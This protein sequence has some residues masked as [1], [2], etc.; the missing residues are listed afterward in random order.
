MIDSRLNQVMSQLREGIRIPVIVELGTAP[1]PA[2]LQELRGAGLSVTTT[3]QISP[4]VYGTATS[5]IIGTIAANPIVVKVFYDEPLYP[6]LALPFGLEVERQEVVPLGES[7]AATGA[8]AL[9]EQGITG[10]GVKIGVV[11]TG[12]SQSHE[13]ISP[14]LKGTFSAVPGESVEDENHHGSW[15]CSAA[16]GRPVATE[17]GELVGAAPEA[18]LYALKA[19]SDKGTG[20][21]SWVMQCIEKAAVDFKCDVISMSLGSLFDNG[22]LDPVSKLVNDV[23]QKY[24]VLCAVAA[25]NSFIPLSIG[26]PGGAISA[27]TVGSYALRLPL[28]GTPSS[29]ESKGP[30]TSLVIKPDTSAPG[31]NIMAPGIAEMILAAGAHGSYQS[32]AGTSMATPQAAGALAL[33]RQAKPDL[34]RI[35]VEQ[36]LAISSFPAPKDTL[37]G[38]GPI[39]ADTMYGNMGRALPPITQFQAPLNALQSMFYAPLTLIPRPENER[40]RVVR[41]P[42]IMGG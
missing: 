11:D 22:G 16:A 14:G 27:V 30:T 1:T 23:V 24:N 25:G 26:S 40:L 34:S 9:W 17:Q 13:M 3:S 7:V 38:Y 37:R 15:C 2:A 6:A 8:P 18:D 36:L 20:Q 41:L 10:K 12:T 32:M 35:E 5:N 29:F 21:M 31:G 42:A 4:L 33:L 39:R 19:L 28:A